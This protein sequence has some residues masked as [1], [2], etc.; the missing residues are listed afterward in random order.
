MISSEMPG[1]PPRL[2]L[3]FFE[4]PAAEVAPDLIGCLLLHDGVGGIVVEVERYQEDDPASHSF[5]GP[6][7]R[8]AIMFGPPGRAYVY[9]SYGVHWCMNVVCDREGS[10]SAV[11]IRAIEPTH[12]IARMRARRGTVPDRALCAGPGRLTQAMG[13]DAAMNGVSLLD[14]PISV[15]ERVA[16]VDIVAGP[17]IGITR[18][19]RTPWR[20]GLAGSRFL[21]RPFPP[22]MTGGRGGARRAVGA[23]R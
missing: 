15:H 4:R 8:A 21:S 20:F 3:E 11:L 22:A 23:A 7:P 6:T 19:T 10:G 18:A 17:R 1:V 13:I 14:G 5:R 9:R 12:G 16:E 2:T